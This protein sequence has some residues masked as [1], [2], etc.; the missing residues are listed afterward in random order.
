MTRE[1]GDAGDWGGGGGGFRPADVLSG[2]VNRWRL[3][4]SVWFVV[5]AA[6]VGVAHV[7]P[8]RYDAYA[9][10]QIDPRK[11]SIVEVESVVSD[12]KAD[13]TT[14][15]SEIEVLRSRG[16]AQRVII[17]LGLAARRGA[18]GEIRQ[19]GDAE[20]SPR[21]AT[22]P[23]DPIASPTG[24]ATDSLVDEIIN[25]MRVA[26]VRATFNIEVRYSSRDPVEAAR[27]ANAVIDA[28]IAQQIEE[29]SASTGDASGLLESRLEGLRTKVAEAEQRVADFRAEQRLLDVDGKLLAERQLLR[30]MEQAVAARSTADE[31]RAKFDQAARMRARG[32]AAAGVADVLQNGTI[33]LLRDQLA[34]V[35]RRAAELSSRY[36]ERHPE[37]RKATAEVRDTEAQIAAEVERVIAN[38]KS[39]VEVAAQRERAYQSELERLREQQ[40]VLRSANVKLQELQREADA[41]R[42]LYE[43]FLGRYKQT[44]AT[45]GLQLPDA[46]IIERADVPPAPAAPK[47]G[48][49]RIAG[50]VAGLGLGLSLALLLEFAAPGFRRSDDLERELDVDTLTPVP[51]VLDANGQPVDPNA[52]VRLLLATPRSPFAEAVRG[53]R[54]EVDRRR[55]TP[56][57]RIVLVVSSLPG[58]GKSMIASNLAHLYATSGVRTLLIDADMRTA[59]LTRALLD[60]CATGLRECLESGSSIDEAILVDR[61]SG[62]AFLAAHDGGPSRAE[63]AELLGSERAR[64]A[65][66]VIRA[67]FDTVVIDAPPLLPVVDA[68]ILADAADQIVLVTAWRSTP[69]ELARR[70]LRSLADNADR[71]VGVVVNRVDP[72]E[73]EVRFGYGEMDPAAG[74]AVRRR[75]A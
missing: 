54:H 3:V 66:E 16:I 47:R 24:L 75:A 28:Y 63:P 17:A 14:V 34:K 57:G 67:E 74:S 69:K 15:D 58:E 64:G 53:I 48:L 50:V 33:R 43:T 12:L 49:I 55:V 73:P 60:G 56:G 4:V 21:D 1:F 27:I 62:L 31:A 8:V 20:S 68:R 18:A 44:A 61:S 11:R 41:S 23:D 30:V 46:R 7:L 29:K 13:H 25:N 9:Y 59:R 22:G 2:L 52:A 38:L 42:Q 51:L 72:S 35:T 40:T 36:G 71:L 5:A 19:G 10:V 45:Q 6:A 70:A 32:E 26:R 37:M 39:D 65:F